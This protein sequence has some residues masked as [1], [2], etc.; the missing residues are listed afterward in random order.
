[1]NFRVIVASGLSVAFASPAGAQS[2]TDAINAALAPIPNPIP[3]S[4]EPATVNCGALVGA[5]WFQ[6]TWQVVNPPDPTVTIVNDESNTTTTAP[7]PVL[8]GDGL[9]RQFVVEPSN[10][11][12]LDPAVAQSLSEEELFQLFAVSGVQFVSIAHGPSGQFGPGLAGLCQTVFARTNTNGNSSGAG[13]FAGGSSSASGRSISSLSSAREQAAKERKRKKKKDR[14]SAYDDGYVRLASAEGGVGLVANASGVGPFGVETFIDLR[15]GYT[16][17]NRDATALEGG[18]DGHST[19]VHGSVTTELSENFAIAGSFAYQRSEGEFDA[20]NASGGANEFSERNY[21]GSGF[22]IASFPLAGGGAPLSLDLA[23]GGFYGGGDG[24]IERTFTAMRTSAYQIDVTDPMMGVTTI[25]II[26]TISIS[27]DLAGDYDTRNYG[28]SAAASLNIDLGGLSVTPGVEFTH[29]TFKQDAYDETVTDSFNNGLALS[30]SKFK[31]R[32]TETRIGGAIARAFGRFRL[33]GYGDLVLTGGSA[34]PT[35]TA[36]FV[37]D[38]RADPYDL[39]Y[40]VDDL[41]KS[42]G[43]FGIVGAAGLADGVEAFLGG[44]TTAGHAY[45]KARTIFAGIRFTP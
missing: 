32:W 38:L 4:F 39:V 6:D 1:M 10:P 2:L 40:E 14:N 23:A 16:D 19:F 13:G 3:G 37:E 20:G 44:E 36:T 42:F 43:V 28:F 21:T 26:R 12:T 33:E 7:A 25:D 29:F 41:D 8:V 45:L 5:T 18:F 27:D 22:L 24:E 9:G 11:Q 17:I 30:Y 34:T 31:D 15:G 35:R